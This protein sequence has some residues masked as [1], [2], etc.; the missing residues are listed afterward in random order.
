[1]SGEHEF[2]V[3][4]RTA[5]TLD[6]FGV[7]T[8]QSSSRRMFPSWAEILGI[9]E[10]QLVG[11]DLPIN[12]PP[13]V[14]RRAVYQI[15]HDPL[16]LGAII[17]THKINVLN[18]ARDLFDELTEDAAL[19]GEV[20]CIY[21]RDGRLIGH[22]TDPSLS[23]QSM[24]RFIRPGHW[25]DTRADVLCLG[26]GGSA[27]AIVVHF[28]LRSQPGDR[29][30]R[31]VIVNRSRP[32]LESLQA[33]VEDRL[34]PDDV[35]FEFIHNADPRENDRLLGMLPPGSMV[36]NA[37]GMGKDSP[38]SPITDEA[39]FP[40]QGIAW[41]L[42]YRGELDFLHQ[43]RAQMAARR[44]TV[45]DGW[46][47]FLLGWSEIIARVFDVEVTPARFEQLARAAEAI[48]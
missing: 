36:I 21:Q 6:F 22:A 23:G 28:L 30:R 42:N 3:E 37:T 13:E 33:L 47:Y 16:S 9:P 24:A 2:A 8:G 38:G 7:T 45:E 5:P 15:K 26:A 32:R 10:A 43:A 39:T 41:E 46:I 19:C 18:A 35:A 17:T 31:M 12:G 27:V 1:M 11:V 20:S 40:Q 14:Y 34:R 48:R 25:R 44:L 29:P 4:A